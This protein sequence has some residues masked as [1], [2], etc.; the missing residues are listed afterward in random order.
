[1]KINGE[2]SVNKNLFG[3]PLNMT[4]TTHMDVF[5]RVAE[6]KLHLDENDDLDF[7]LSVRCFEHVC[8]I[9]SVWVFIGSIG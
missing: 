6:T 5:E 9:F 3:F 8:H 4:Y 2:V 7:V 1:M